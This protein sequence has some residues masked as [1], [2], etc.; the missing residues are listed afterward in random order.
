MLQETIPPS[1]VML[2]DEGDY[3]VPKCF[4][5]LIPQQLANDCNFFYLLLN[6]T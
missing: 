6:D 1:G 2:P 4:M 3:Y 5:S